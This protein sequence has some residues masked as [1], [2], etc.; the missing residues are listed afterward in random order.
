[1][2]VVCFCKPGEEPDGAVNVRRYDDTWVTYDTFTGLCLAEREHNTYHDSDFFM[3]VWDDAAN[4]PREIC[5]AS[6]RGWTY[7][8]MA[9][10]VDATPDIVAKWNAWKAA[11]AAEYKRQK[12][13]AKAQ[14]LIAL[15]AKLK[16]IAADNNVNYC[17]LLRLRHDECFAGYLKLFGNVRSNF[18]LSL[19]NQLVAWLNGKSQYASPLS[20]RQ[21]QC[22]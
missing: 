22:L 6:T 7:P 10:R 12:R 20:Y 2:P 11:K 17:R 1:M 19:R 18:K 15:R 9:S 14:E 3:T 5:F 16:K 4:A 21:K 13:Q 8:S